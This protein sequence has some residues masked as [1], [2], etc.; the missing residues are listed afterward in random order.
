MMFRMRSDVVRERNERVDYEAE[1]LG[2]LIICQLERLMQESGASKA[3]LAR[4]L[5]CHR[6]K[7]TRM[8]SVGAN[9]T[10]RSVAA[11]LVALDSRLSVTVDER[12]ANGEP[13]LVGFEGARTSGETRGHRSAR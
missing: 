3:E 7:V 6:S 13:V 9:L 5:G 8:F 4:R 12:S 10:L 2:Q 11:V 1:Y